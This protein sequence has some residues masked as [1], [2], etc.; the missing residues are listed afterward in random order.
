MGGRVGHVLRL[1]L[2]VLLP[3]HK[4]RFHGG[5]AAQADGHLAAEME[6][7]VDGLLLQVPESV[8]QNLN[9]EDGDDEEGWYEGYEWVTRRQAREFG[10]FWSR[11]PHFERDF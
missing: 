1:K 5:R 3:V 7:L 11:M 2:K 6:L 8:Q 9:D 10:E 4:R